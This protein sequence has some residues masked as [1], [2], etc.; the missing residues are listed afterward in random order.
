MYRFSRIPV[1]FQSRGKGSRERARVVERV[2]NTTF[3]FFNPEVEE[4]R[5]GAKI[6]KEEVGKSKIDEWTVEVKFVTTSSMTISDF[7]AIMRKMRG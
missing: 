1:I 2:N 4:N 6:E 5:K 3:N 7:H